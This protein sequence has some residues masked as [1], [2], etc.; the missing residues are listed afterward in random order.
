MLGPHYISQ[1]PD[2]ARVQFAPQPA[3]FFESQTRVDY[4]DRAM[5]HKI[6]ANFKSSA[7]SEPNFAKAEPDPSPKILS[8]FQLYY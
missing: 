2:E 5:T 8:L 6:T 1:M 7:G 4:K 3:G